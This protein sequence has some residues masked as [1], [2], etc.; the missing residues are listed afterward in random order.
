MASR[1][2]DG[3]ELPEH[4]KRQVRRELDRLELLLDQIKGVEAVSGRSLSRDSSDGR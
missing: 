1:S 4:L 2:A 3:R